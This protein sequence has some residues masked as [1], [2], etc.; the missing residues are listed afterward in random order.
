MNKLVLILLTL[1][2]P[3]LSYA[4]TKASRN[5]NDSLLSKLNETVKSVE[6]DIER[7]GRY[8]MYQTDN[9]YILIKLDTSTGIIKLTQW[10][11]DEDEEFEVYVNS[12][13]LSK[14]AILAKKGRFELYPTKNMYQWILLDTMFGTTWHVQWGTKESERWIRQISIF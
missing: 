1:C 9:L 3:V 6:F 10:S 2:V 12:D 7:Y 8:K 5:A 14:S 13:D 4:Q 11:L